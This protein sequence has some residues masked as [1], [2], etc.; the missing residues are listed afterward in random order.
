[1]ARSACR[2]I[3]SSGSRRGGHGADLVA[4]DIYWWHDG[5]TLVTRSKKVPP[6]RAVELEV[7]KL[8]ESA[9]F[10]A[11]RNARVAKPRHTDML[12]QPGRPLSH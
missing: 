4:R 6:G 11:H 12:A 7:L 5:P 1:M 10:R 2:P 9:G 3:G 8:L